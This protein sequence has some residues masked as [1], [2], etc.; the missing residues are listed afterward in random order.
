MK[1]CS[2][3]KCSN[4]RLY[5]DGHCIGLSVKMFDYTQDIVQYFRELFPDDVNALDENLKQY[6]YPEYTVTE[7]ELLELL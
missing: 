7:N 5:S 2:E 6:L 3:N 1:I 4:C